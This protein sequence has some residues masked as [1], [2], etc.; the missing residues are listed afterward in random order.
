ML[1]ISLFFTAV[2]AVRGHTLAA[3]HVRN[4]PLLGSESPSQVSVLD[5]LAGVKE[6]VT[7]RDGW[8]LFCLV[9]HAASLENET[10]RG[11]QKMYVI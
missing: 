5:H 4:F 8:R 10:N 2:E 7:I 6:I 1:S 9:I 11:E 3:N